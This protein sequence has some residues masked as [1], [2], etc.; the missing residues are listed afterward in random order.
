MTRTRAGL[1]GGF[2]GG[3]VSL[4]L[5]ANDLAS[6]RSLSFAGV[7]DAA[8]QDR[9]LGVALPAMVSF[10]LRLLLLMLAAGGLAGGLGG[11]AIGGGRAR[12][13]A[14]GGL[15]ALTLHV[16]SLL[17][18]MGRYPQLYADR[19]WLAGGPRATIQSVATHVV[20]PVVFDLAFLAVL[21]GL[22]LAGAVR[23]RALWRRAPIRIAAASVGL[24]LAAALVGGRL[25]EARVVTAGGPPSVLLI[26]VDSLREDRMLSAEVMPTVSGLVGEGTLFRHAF[27]PVARTVPSWVSLLTG[28]EPRHTGVRTMFPDVE[29]RQKLGPSFVAELRDAGYRTFVVSDFA[30]D[31]FPRIPGGFDDVDTPNLTAASLTRSTVLSAHG[32]ALP[33]L[34]LRPLRAALGEWRNLASL[35]DPEWLA[36]RTLAHLRAARGRPYAGAVFFGT[37][38]FPYV[39]P[40][41]DYLT[42]AGSYRGRYLYHAPPTLGQ[43]APSPED[44]AQVRARYDG[45]VRATDR[46]IARIISTLRRDAA[47]DRTL[48]VITSD[49]GEEL[50]EDAG[51]AGHGDT[52]GAERSQLVPILLRGPG[53]E[54]GRVR[55][56][57]VRLYDL[58][59]TILGLALGRAGRSFGDGLD[60]RV[61]GALRPACLETGIWFFPGLPPGLVGKRLQY[62]GIAELLE[63]VPATGE[64]VLRR[65]LVPTVESA[66]ARG[67]VLGGRLWT[68][69]LTPSGR[70]TGLRRLP[71]I[72]PAGEAEDIAALFEE[73]CVAGDPA[74]G[75]FLDAVVWAAP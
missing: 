21:L 7:S 51:I 62:P 39:A 43:N 44:V 31:M 16:L 18:M 49:H 6:L 58:G 15:A 30:G 41:P 2:A 47:L 70:V 63:V 3:F 9:L 1:L 65:D 40:Y 17:G 22:V 34:R 66:K 4:A 12:R 25:L 56:D 20:G 26:V 73:R 23:E 38:H 59:A 29:S 11:L 61:E 75:R 48:V 28:M 50:Y 14:A 37:P 35:S 32:F 52:I 8:T 10:E 71:A 74:L 45:A 33:F 19:Y 42:G 55:T 5:W 69:Q 57:Q 13:L 53:V 27:T 24:L 46:A 68:E 64:F 72:P 60:L 67:L 36:D 54:A